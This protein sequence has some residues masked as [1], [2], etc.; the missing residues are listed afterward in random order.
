MDWLEIVKVSFQIVF[1]LIIS[2]VTILTY[3]RARRTILQPIRTEV[4]KL[5]LEEMAKVLKIFSGKTE[6]ELRDDYSFEK[7]FYVNACRMYDDYAEIFFDIKNDPKGRPYNRNECPVSMFSKEYAEENL[8]LMDS[9]LKDDSSI[10]QNN[11]PIDLRVRAA[12]WHKYAYGELHIPKEFSDFEKNLNDLL[13]NPLLPLQLVTQIQSYQYLVAENLTM[14]GKL[15]EEK[16]QEMDDKYPTVEKLQQ[17]SYDWIHTLYV[18]RFK[19]LKPT[20]DQIALYVRS[21]FK[22]DELMNE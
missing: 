18:E 17:S 19:T 9:H 7:I 1:W 8:I 5:Q 22:T 21:Y 4:F 10:E 12:R 16:A 2:I 20:A 15:L 6:I 11:E 3:R 14:I 13:E